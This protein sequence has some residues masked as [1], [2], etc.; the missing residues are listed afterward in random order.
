MR[1]DGLLPVALHHGGE[2]R[3]MPVIQHQTRQDQAS[4]AYINVMQKNRKPARNEYFVCEQV[5]KALTIR[6]KGRGY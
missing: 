5:V 3:Q 1:E 4:K 6:M 2:K